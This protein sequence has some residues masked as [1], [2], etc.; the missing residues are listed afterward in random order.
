MPSP[1]H[2]T[3]ILSGPAFLSQDT[4]AGTAGP[5]RARLTDLL[6]CVNLVLT[7]SFQGKWHCHMPVILTSGGSQ[8]EGESR[9]TF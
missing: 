7:D 3:L 9:D 8:E 6:K 2:G 4:G 1:G 5:L